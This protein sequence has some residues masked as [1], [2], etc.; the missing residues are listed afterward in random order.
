MRSSRWRP[1]TP[2]ETVSGLQTP[3]A[4]YC[5]ELVKKHD[6][7]RWLAAGYAGGEDRRKLIALYAFRTVLK[8]IPSVVSEPPLG[9]IRLQWQRE[10]FAALRAGKAPRVHPV[11]EEIAAAG[12][13][14][15]TFAARIDA[16][17]DAHAR[18]LYGEGFADIEGLADWLASSEGVFDALAVRLLGGDEAA[19]AMALSAGVA[20]ALARDGAGL[21]PHLKQEIAPHIREI[22]ARAPVSLKSIST[23]TAPAILHL[24]LTEVYLRRGVSPFPLLK[25]ARLFLAMASGRF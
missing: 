15:E 23:R 12:L 10:A 2:V 22:L 9:E 20:F 21:A 18:L 1:L 3:S 8:R 16:A 4:V 6:E 13:G 25:R 7:D 5:A 14:A 24:A 11:M 17:I 19:A